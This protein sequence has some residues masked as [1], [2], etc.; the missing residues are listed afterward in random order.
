MTQDYDFLLSPEIRHLRSLLA[1]AEEKGLEVSATHPE[2]RPAFSLM[3]D[4]QKFDFFRARAY[5]TKDGERFSFDDLYARRVTIALD[6]SAV[7]VPSIR[8]LILTKRTRNSPR[9]QEDIKY[10]QVILE[11][12]VS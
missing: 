11:R 1:L 6:K 4:T 7:Y 3:S 5:S 8:D 12:G 10:L 2:K 9:D